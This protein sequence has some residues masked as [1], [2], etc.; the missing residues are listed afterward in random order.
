MKEWLLIYWD[1]ILFSVITI[2]IAWIFYKYLSKLIQKSLKVLGKDL[3]APKTVN[4]FMGLVISIF[5]ILVLLNIWNVDLMPYIAGL[6]ISGI[7]VGLALQEPLAN[8]ISG[9]LVMTTRK[10]FEGEV[11]DVNGISG[12]VDEIKINHSYLRTFDGKLVLLPNKSVWSGTV[13]K[14][15]PGP[16][17]RVKMDVGVS[18]N[19]DLETVLK[20][21]Q[22]AIDEEPLVVKDGVSNFIAFKQFGSSSI[23]FTVYFWV[24]RSTY[25][26]AVNAL[27]VRIKKIFD[28]EGVE[29]PFTQIDVHM[30]N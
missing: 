21:L 28:D 23:D 4:F 13:T 20:L 27:A 6:G 1:E 24:E 17:R 2:I 16:V 14:F 29:I 9:I 30:K 15:W 7:V 8:F 19:S 25:F 26:D 22:R 11:V 5:A 10:L 3:K 18:Y 12:I